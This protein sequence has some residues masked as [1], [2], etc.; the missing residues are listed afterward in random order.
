MKN[1][2]MDLLKRKKE[3]VLKCKQKSFK[4]EVRFHRVLIMC[5]AL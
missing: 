3:F 4:V 1:E 2:V 5:F